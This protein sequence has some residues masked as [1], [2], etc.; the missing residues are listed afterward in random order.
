MVNLQRVQFEDIRKMVED[1]SKFEGLPEIIEYQAN[2][3]EELKAKVEDIQ[4]HVVVHTVW[5]HE[6]DK[7]ISLLF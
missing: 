3:I 7:V 5:L 4:A 2:N 1:T 6:S